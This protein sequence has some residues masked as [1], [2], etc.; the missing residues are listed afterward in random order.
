MIILE[1]NRLTL[2]R[3]VPDDL[4]ALYALYSDPEMRLYFPVEGVSP[5][6]TLTREETKEELDWFLD[7][8][9]K[10]SELGLSRCLRAGR[11]K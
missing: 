3:L 7:G 2:R 11:A 10:H 8:H 5:D 9:P 1:T 6:R 4:D